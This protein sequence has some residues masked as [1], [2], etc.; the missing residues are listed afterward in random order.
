MYIVTFSHFS[1]NL[2]GTVQSG[3]DIILTGY[4]NIGESVTFYLGS[5]R[6]NTLGVI[7]GTKG[8]YFCT[9]LFNNHKSQDR[10]CFDFVQLILVLVGL[11]IS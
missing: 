11:R 1:Q 5:R 10:Q 3:A 6:R 9:T 2:I 8:D 4:G 7:L